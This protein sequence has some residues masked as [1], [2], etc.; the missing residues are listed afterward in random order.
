MEHRRIAANLRTVINRMRH[1][2]RIFNLG[3][4]FVAVTLYRALRPR[5][6]SAPR[7]PRNI[8][9]V[10]LDA[11][12]DVLMTTGIFHALRRSYPRA[13]ITAVV[14]QRSAAIVETNP[15][16]NHVV[17]LPAVTPTR[18]LQRLREELAVFGLYR[19]VLRRQPFDV[20]LQPRSGF[21]CAAENLLV[22][23]LD[24][25]RTLRYRDQAS[26]PARL[27]LDQ[28][29]G[30]ATNLERGAPLHEVQ[31]NSRLAAQ[32]TGR[33]ATW[34]P[35]I[36]LREKDREFSRQLLEK[37]PEETI[38]VAVA[39][40]A[41]ARK[42]EWPLERWAEVMELLAKRWEI[43][44]ILVCSLSERERGREFQKMLGLESSLVADRSIRQAA[45]VIETCALFTGLDS[46]LAHVAA[47]VGTTPV[48]VSPHPLG[49]DPDHDNSPVRFRPY[50]EHA[51]VLQPPSATAPCTT[52]CNGIGPHCILGITPAD[53]ADA[54]DRVLWAAREQRLLSRYIDS[55]R[56]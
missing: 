52:A 56:S 19:R 23:L 12:G 1:R 24:A 46:G 29:F 31:R 25:P 14:Q 16:I 41:Q 30:R 47:A 5:R 9:V 6:E 17:R 36:F 13:T 34:A 48:I 51:V 11:I 26:G 20:V 50:S 40:T 22:K 54:C 44:P 49:G 53:V 21:D 8:L 38:P 15:H 10:R 3:I 2:G 27:L 35:E 33:E 55:K 28:A 42:R 7:E 37:I 43:H 39:F 18:F 45:A 4:L 32:L